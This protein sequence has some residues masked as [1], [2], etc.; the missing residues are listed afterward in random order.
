MGWTSSANLKAFSYVSA[1]KAESAI[2]RVPMIELTY[3]QQE[4]AWKIEASVVLSNVWSSLELDVD[5]ALH[6]MSCY[7]LLYSRCRGWP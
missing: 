7:R 6:V 5:D 2:S 4:T 1:A 3:V